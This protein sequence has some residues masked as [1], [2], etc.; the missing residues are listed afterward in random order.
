MM[1]RVSAVSAQGSVFIMSW[2]R[3]LPESEQFFQQIK[4]KG[5]RCKHL[6]R[7]VFEIR[8]KGDPEDGDAE[9]GDDGMEAFTGGGRGRLAALLAAAGGTAPAG[10]A[11]EVKEERGG[12]GASPS[13]AEDAGGSGGGAANGAPEGG[14]Q[15]ASSN[16]TGGAGRHLA[17]SSNNGDTAA[18][19]AAAD[20][21]AQEGE[22]RGAAAAA[23]CAGAG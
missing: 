20:A 13:G 4:E 19:A 23:A 12:D 17:S 11:P 7:L 18:A 5:F 22:G 15:R 1:I 8:G 16:G 21:P 3:R 14:A 6:G 10:A 9:G 2:Q